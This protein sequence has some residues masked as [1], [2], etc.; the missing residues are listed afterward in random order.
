LPV[1]LST[2]LTLIAASFA[3]S[4]PSKSAGSALLLRYSELELHCDKGCGL[5]NA[6]N[7]MKLLNQTP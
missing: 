6:R 3:G 1:V 4:F 2:T 7:G 5:A